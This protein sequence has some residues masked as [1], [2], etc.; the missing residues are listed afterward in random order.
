MKILARNHFF[1]TLILMIAITVIAVFSACLPIQIG[2]EI[3]INDDGSGSRKIAIYIYD[4][5]VG[6]EGGPNAYHFLRFHGEELGRRVEQKLQENLKDTSWL[7]VTVSNGYGAMHNAE[8]VTLSFSFSSFNDYTR[9]MTSLA[10]FGKP[11]FPKDS[12]F[13]TPKLRRAPNNQLRYIETAKT[14]WWTVRPLFLAV[15]N[16]PALFDITC[17]GLNNQYKREDLI[18]ML[19]TEGVFFKAVLGA[20]APRLF[21][22]GTNIDVTFPRGE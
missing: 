5:D 7:T 14:Q 2:R 12:E 8:I 19:Q 6:R 13:E 21:T 11:F 9:K 17:R 22:S 18:D 4:D 16:D 15:F 20:N 10:K 3:V 1:R